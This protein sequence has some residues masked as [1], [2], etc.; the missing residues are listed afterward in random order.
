M[1]VLNDDELSLSLP[2]FL[3]LL[4]LLLLLFLLF[5]IC[6]LPSRLEKAFCAGETEEAKASCLPTLG[7]LEIDSH[8]CKQ[9]CNSSALERRGQQS[10]LK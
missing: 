7:F 5:L 1:F 2:P 3:P 8:F 9:V 6:C 4:F 10:L